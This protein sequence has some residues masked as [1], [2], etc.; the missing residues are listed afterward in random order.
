DGANVEIA[1]R[2]GNENCQIFGLKDFEVAKMRLE[3]SYNPWDIYNSDYEIKELMDSLLTGLWSDGD[4]E[5]YRIIFD[6]IMYRGDEYFVLKDLKPYM[7][8]SASLSNK[9]EDKEAWAKAAIINIAKSGHFSSD[10]TIQQYVDE[11][12]HLKKVNE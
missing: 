8:A 1:E 11:I 2:V 4:K 10:R 3:S 12:W 5:K 9:Y 6:E 7:E